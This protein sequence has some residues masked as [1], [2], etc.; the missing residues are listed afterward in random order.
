MFDY[1]PHYPPTIREMAAKDETIKEYLARTGLVPT[2]V[3][4]HSLG[5]LT[6]YNV[7]GRTMQAGL[8]ATGKK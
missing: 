2:E 6:N 7:L 3:P 8:D 4:I 1:Y 5:E